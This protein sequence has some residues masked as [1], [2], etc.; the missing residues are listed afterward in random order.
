MFPPPLHPR[1]TV[2]PLYSDGGIL[3]TVRIVHEQGGAG[4]DCGGSGLKSEAGGIERVCGDRRGGIDRRIRIDVLEAQHR[5]IGAML[6]TAIRLLPPVIPY[7][8]PSNV[9]LKTWI[10]SGMLA[11]R[12]SSKVS[13]LSIRP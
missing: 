3:S 11:A 2:V 5:R 9:L 4:V 12:K 1:S 13:A 7:G 6:F 8:L 10:R